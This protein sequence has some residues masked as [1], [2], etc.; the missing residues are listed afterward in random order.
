M[1]KYIDAVGLKI[2]LGKRLSDD[3]SRIM[4]IVKE[5]IDSIPAI[6]IVRCKECKHCLDEVIEETMPIYIYCDLWKSET[7]WDSFCSYGER[8]DNE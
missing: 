6:D 2:K 7:E 8:K 4:E 1:S 5:T 3:E